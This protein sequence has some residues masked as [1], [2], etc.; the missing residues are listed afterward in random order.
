M[1][2]LCQKAKGDETMPDKYTAL[3]KITYYC[4]FE[5]YTEN[6]IL[7]EVSDFADAARRIEEYYGKD[8]QEMKITLYDC[9]FPN[10]EDAD[11]KKWFAQA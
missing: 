3:A 5:E 7:S 2:I 10:P 6:I 9:W 4:D 8:L 1:P 11:I